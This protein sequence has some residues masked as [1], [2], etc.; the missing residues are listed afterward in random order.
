MNR[1]TSRKFLLAVAVA[2]VAFL[3]EFTGV[4]IPLEGLV[5]VLVFI[6]FEGTKDIVAEL[7]KRE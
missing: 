3:K 4:E 6:G 2:L 7:K 1:F 5:A